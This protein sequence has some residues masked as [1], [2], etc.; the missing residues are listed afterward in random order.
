MTATAQ[1][2][3]KLELVSIVRRE[4]SMTQVWFKAGVLVYTE[5]WELDGSYRNGDYSMIDLN[6]VRLEWHLKKK[7]LLSL[8]PDRRLDPMAICLDNA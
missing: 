5:I 8:N 1:E 2:A 6:A 4:D 7:D 3:H